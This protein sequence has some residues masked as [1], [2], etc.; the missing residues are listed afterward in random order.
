MIFIIIFSRI[1]A[2]SYLD[3]VAYRDISN[4]TTSPYI[5]Y[6]ISDAM[7]NSTRVF[8][9]DFIGSNEKSH[10]RVSECIGP[11]VKFNTCFSHFDGSYHV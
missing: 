3:K 6:I 8:C 2:N 4:G 5:G 1:C 7:F 11:R 9:F 10:T